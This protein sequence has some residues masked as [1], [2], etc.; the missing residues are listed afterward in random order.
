[1]NNVV[2]TVYVL[3]FRNIFYARTEREKCSNFITFTVLLY[4]YIYIYIEREAIIHK[5][6]CF[7]EFIK[8]VGGKEI[9]C[10]AFWVH[11]VCKGY[12]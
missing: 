11:T 4:I 8:R 2:Y 9:K 6:S 7:I 1:M 12:K 5:C 3:K 10:E